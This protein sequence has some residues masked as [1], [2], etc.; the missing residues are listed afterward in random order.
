MRLERIANG[1]PGFLLHN[2]AI[3][4]QMQLHEAFVFS[5]GARNCKEFSVTGLVIRVKVVLQ[6]FQTTVSAQPIR[7][8]NLVNIATI[9]PSRTLI[10][11]KDLSKYDR[12]SACDVAVFQLDG[13]SSIFRSSNVKAFRLWYCCIRDAKLAA[14][15]N[16]LSA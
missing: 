13:F 2:K 3:T 7:E 15:I 9:K 1:A 5:E 11:S 14:V 8:N 6:A 16:T 10:A 4:T 12:C